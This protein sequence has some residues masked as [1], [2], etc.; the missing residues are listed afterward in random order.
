MIISS[1]DCLGKDVNFWCCGTRD[2]EQEAY[3]ADEII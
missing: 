1:T 2:L 3:V